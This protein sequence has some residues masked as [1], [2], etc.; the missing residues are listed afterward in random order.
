MSRAA[1]GRTRQQRRKR[2][3]AQRLL[4][5]RQEAAGIRKPSHS[6]R[7]N[8]TSGYQTVEEEQQGRTEAALEHA[9]LIRQQLPIL[10]K[11][12]SKIPDPRKPLLLKHKLSTLMVYGILM[13]V[14][15]TGSR[16][17]TNERLTAPAMR[18]ALL[19]LFPDLE[20]IP[21]H[22]TLYRLLARI[23][24]EGIEAAQVEL[25]RALIRH[26]K[27]R[28][29]LVEGNHLIAIDGTQ[30]LV[31]ELLPDEGWS[32][33]KVGAE[34]KQYTQYYTYV[35]EA[36][37]VLRNGVSLPLMSEFLDYREGDSEREK[38][39]CEQRGFLR[40][41][42][43]L[44][45]AFPNLKILVVLDGLYP[46]GPVMQRLR[47]Y[48]WQFMIV[49]KDG[50]LR[51]VWQEY[52]GLKHYQS[53][54][55]RLAQRWGDRE[56]QFDWV[57]DIEYA[58]GQNGKQWLKVHLVVCRES[59]KEVDAKGV[60]VQRSAKWA[61]LSSLPFSRR[62][63]HVRC[64]IGGRGRW[65]IEEGILVE[66]RQG[67][68]YE[69]CY[70]LAW[71]AMCCY[72]YLMRIGHLLNVLASLSVSLLG[73]FKERG[74]QGFIEWVRETL[75]GRWLELSQLQARLRAPFQLR[76]LLPPP[77]FPQPSG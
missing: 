36:N 64:N 35:L 26:K 56:Q 57:D 30:K 21:H 60:V 43:R 70:A 28:D 49:L 63:V 13:F 6:T 73:A 12:L 42:L 65:S 37:L 58:Y 61:W 33:R 45:R 10:L 20:S 38:Q 34:G 62:T 8:R 44:K 53:D 76:L 52:E 48:G 15:Q 75:S 31:R 4:R 66:K 5:K 32:E 68:E 3:A 25:L 22:D 47:D 2:R 9:R 24:P 11:R 77:Q 46:T 40:L 69:H 18:E 67:Y 54:E 74:A 16:R 55:E 59:W 41:S 50:S 51:Q 19:G 39:D 71:N 1:R 17:R 14:L 72:H 29:Y 7:P 27:F 23:E